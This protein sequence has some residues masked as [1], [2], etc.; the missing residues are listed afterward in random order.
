VL[1]VV[2]VVATAPEVVELAADVVDADVALVAA[3]DVSTV[4]VGSGEV[5]GEVVARALITSAAL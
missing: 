3:V 2:V 4:V 1:P 5:V